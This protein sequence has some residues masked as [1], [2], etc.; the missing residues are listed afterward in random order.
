[1]MVVCQ[2]LPEQV[3]NKE[4]QVLLKQVG[5]IFEYATRKYPLQ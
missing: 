2:V 3:K 5:A 1:M 4:K